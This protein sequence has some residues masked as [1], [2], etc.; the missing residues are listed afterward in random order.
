VPSAEQ[1]AEVAEFVQSQAEREP[2]PVATIAIWSPPD[3]HAEI[4]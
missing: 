4:E 1:I 3:G 2:G